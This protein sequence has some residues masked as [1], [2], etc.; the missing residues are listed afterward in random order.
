LD[1]QNLFVAGQSRDL[2]DAR[3]R[4]RYKIEVDI[5]VYSRTCGLLKGRTVDISESGIAVM[6]RLE[7]PFGELVELNFTLTSGSM[8]I[9]ATVRQ[10]NAF[11]YGFEFVNSESEHELIRRACRD[12]AVEQS[13]L[14]SAI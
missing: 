11:R 10:R 5:T 13:V 6:L 9:L 2:V 14:P 4:P 8:T 12:L 3:R 1:V 7:V